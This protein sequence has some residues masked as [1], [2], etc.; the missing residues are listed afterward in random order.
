MPG[1][2]VHR[3]SLASWPL[4]FVVLGLCY[5]DVA[6]SYFR[7]G[8]LN[9][10]PTEEHQQ[11]NKAKIE[12]ELRAAFR[13]NYQ[14][15]KYYEQE[16]AQTT[17]FAAPLETEWKSIGRDGEAG[18]QANP[19][20]DDYAESQRDD[21]KNGVVGEQFFVKFVP[22]N[23]DL[24]RT[25]AEF[26]KACPTPAYCQENPKLCASST[27]EPKAYSSLCTA[28]DELYGLYLGDGTSE[29][30][31]FK[32]SQMDYSCSESSSDQACDTATGNF[33]LGDGRVSHYYES[34][35]D[36]PFLA[37]FTG[38]D[39]LSE[40]AQGS[41]GGCCLNSAGVCDETGLSNLLNNNAEGRFRL[42]MEIWVK[43]DGNRSPQVGQVPV[44]PVPRGASFADRQRFQVMAFD[45]DQDDLVFRFGTS[46]EMGGS[47]RD[48]T[49]SA[50]IGAS[51]NSFSTAVPG[52][53]EWS[54][55][56]DDRITPL[57]VGLYN[58]VV[59]VFDL[60]SKAEESSYKLEGR[61]VAYHPRHPSFSPASRTYKSKVPVDFL[62]YLY[63]GVAS[64]CNKACKAAEESGVPTFASRNGQYDKCTV[65]G[66]GT[67]GNSSLCQPVKA[68]G[69]CGELDSSGSLVPAAGACQVNQPPVWSPTHEA[70][71]GVLVNPGK[72]AGEAKVVVS[73]G[74]DF[75][76][77]VEAAD[78][79]SCTE[80][81]L[82]D[83][84]L[85][86]GAD[87]E[88][89]KIMP[90]GAIRRKFSWPAPAGHLAGIL[91]DSRE[92]YSRVC[93]YASDKYLQSQEGFY[94]VDLE[95]AVQKQKVSAPSA[96]RARSL[97]ATE[98]MQVL[99]RFDCKQLLTW[100]S[101]ERRFCFDDG[102]SYWCS[103]DQY[104]DYIWHHAMYTISAEGS[105]RLV[106]DGVVQSLVVYDTSSGAFV[107][108][109][110]GNV[111]TTTQS[112]K[113]GGTCSVRMGE[114]C[115]G[116]SSE[117]Y[118]FEGLV[119][120]VAIWDRELTEEEAAYTLFKMPQQLPGKELVAPRGDQMC[121]EKG[122]ILYARY[123]SPC[124]TDKEATDGDSC[125]SAPPKNQ[126]VCLNDGTM[127]SYN[128]PAGY[129]A[130]SEVYCNPQDKDCPPSLANSPYTYYKPYSLPSSGSFFTTSDVP[131]AYEGS[132]RVVYTSASTLFQQVA[133]APYLSKYDLHNPSQ[134]D[135]AT[136]AF[137]SGYSN[138]DGNI[139][140]FQD[141]PGAEK[142]ADP[143]STTNGYFEG[144]Y[145]TQPYGYYEAATCTLPPAAFPSDRYYFGVSND[146]GNTGSPMQEPITYMDYALSLEA[147]TERIQL[148]ES[149]YN[150]DL[151]EQFSLSFWVYAVPGSEG[152]V[153]SMG[154]RITLVGKDGNY[155]V[156]RTGGS[157]ECW[158]PAAS[159][160]YH[161]YMTVDAGSAQLYR[162]GVAFVAQTEAPFLPLTL[163]N[164]TGASLI[165]E[166]K[167]FDG[168][169]SM[170]D[171]LAQYMGT[172]EYIP[173]TSCVLYLRFTNL[174]DTSVLVNE[175]NSATQAVSPSLNLVSTA[176]PWE[177][178][179]V[180]SVNGQSVGSLGVPTIAVLYGEDTSLTVEGFNFARTEQLACLFDLDIGQG[181]TRYGCDGAYSVREQTGISPVRPDGKDTS[182]EPYP[183]M[184]MNNT[185]MIVSEII[186]ESTE[187]VFCFAPGS[188][189]TEGSGGYMGV[190]TPQ[191]VAGMP[192]SQ[193]LTGVPV[194]FL[195][196]S[197]ECTDGGYVT[198]D[199]VSGMV[200]SKGYFFS[201][202][203]YP[204]ETEEMAVALSFES[205][206]VKSTTMGN[207]AQ[208][209]FDGK[210]VY[211]YDD[212]VGDVFVNEGKQPANMWHYVSFSVTEDDKATL[213][214]DGVMTE[215]T[216]GSRPT[217]GGAFSLCMEYAD[218]EAVPSAFFSGL[219]AQ[220]KVMNREVTEEEHA[221]MIL[222][223]PTAFE[224][225]VS[226][227]D[228]KSTASLASPVY[229][230][231]YSGTGEKF[232]KAKAPWEPAT[233]ISSTP[234]TSVE[235]DGTIIVRGGNV[236]PSAF[237][238][239]F[240]GSGEEDEA[241]IQAGFKQVGAV[242]VEGGVGLGS[243]GICRDPAAN[244]LYV[245]NGYHNGTYAHGDPIQYMAQGNDMVDLYEGLLMHY[246][247]DVGPKGAGEPENTYY[248]ASGSGLDVEYPAHLAVADRD[249]NEE[250]AVKI[251]GGFA[252]LVIP[253]DK[254]DVEI[255]EVSVCIWLYM[256][257]EAPEGYSMEAYAPY[258]TDSVAGA[259][260][261]LTYTL[262]AE[263]LETLYVGYETATDM[264]MAFFIP[265]FQQFVSTGELFP[266]LE[267]C[268]DDVWVYA[269]VLSACEA[270]ARS[271]A[272]QHALDLTK[273]TEAVT[274]E[275]EVPNGYEM[276]IE[277]WVFPYS[278]QGR[279]TLF[280][281]DP[282]NVTDDGYAVGIADGR[283]TLSIYFD[284]PYE[285]CGSYMELSD[286]LILPNRWQH[287]AVSFNGTAA[288]FY[289]DGC[290]KDMAVF[291]GI[292]E[293]AA[294]PYAGA[295]VKLVY[296][297]AMG[298]TVMPI[299]LGHESMATKQYE[300]L[301]EAPSASRAFKGLV[302]DLRVTS[303]LRSPADIYAGVVCPARKR[304]PASE[305]YFAMNE[306][307]FTTSGD[308]AVKLPSTTLWVNAS[309]DDESDFSLMKVTGSMASVGYS[310]V[311][312]R[313]VLTMYTS[314]MK[315]RAA[316]GDQIEVTMVDAASGIEGAATVVDALD[317]NYFVEYSKDSLGGCGEFQTTITANQETIATMVTVLSPSWADRN[318]T[319]VEEIAAPTVGTMHTVYIQTY[320][321]YGCVG[322]STDEEFAVTVSGGIELGPDDVEVVALGSGRY[323]ATWVPP[324]EGEYHIH[325]EVASGPDPGPVSN[326][327]HCVT[328]SGYPGVYSFDG[329]DALVVE[330]AGESPGETDLDL[331][332]E[333]LTMQ[334]W[335]WFS[336]LPSGAAYLAVKGNSDQLDKS[337]KG[338]TFM[339]HGS[340]AMVKASIYVG[341]HVYREIAFGGDAIAAGVWVHLAA[342]YDSVSWT[343]YIN[344][345]EAG[346]VKYDEEMM[347]K[348]NLYYH[349]LTIGLGVSGA[350]DELVLWKTARTAEEVSA[351]LYCLHPA[352]EL[353]KVVAYFG[354]NDNTTDRTVVYGA[355]AVWDACAASLAASGGTGAPTCLTGMYSGSRASTLVT[356]EAAYSSPIS[357]GTISA[358]MSV[359]AVAESVT[360]GG[361][362]SAAIITVQDMCG[363]PLVNAGED[364]VQ[365][366]LDLDGVSYST[367]TAVMADPKRCPS[368]PSEDYPMGA[369]YDSAFSLTTAGV[370]TM[371]VVIAGSSLGPYSFTVEPGVPSS[372]AFRTPGEMV[373]GTAGTFG[374]DVLDEFQNLCQ[375]MRDWSVTFT[376]VG[377][378]YTIA[379]TIYASED[380]I[381]YDEG[382]FSMDLD[383]S[384]AGVYLVDLV[385]LPEV[386]ALSPLVSSLTV[387][388]GF[389]EEIDEPTNA[390][391]RYQHTSVV[392]NEDIYI[393]G[394]ALYNKTYS[395][396]LYV[397][398][399]KEE[400]SNTWEY[401]PTYGQQPT[402]R[403]SHTSVLYNNTMY[404]Y[405]GQRSLYAFDDVYAFDFESSTWTLVSTAEGETPAARFD[406]AAAVSDK[407]IMVIS[408]GRTAGSQLLEDMWALNLETNTWT[409][410]QESMSV[411]GVFGHAMAV[412]TGTT[413]AYLFGGY[414]GGGA[415]REF[416]RY[417]V[418]TGEETRLTDGCLSEQYAEDNFLPEALTA[419]FEHTMVADASFL[420]IFGGTGS[421]DSG[422]ATIFKYAWDQCA[423]DEVEL[424]SS[425]ESLGRYEHTAGCIGDGMYVQGG[426]ADGQYNGSTHFFPL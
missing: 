84:G 163:G 137:T 182:F 209:R 266:D 271:T 178:T 240:L 61:E 190:L 80:L 147:P 420:Y 306:G 17:N 418:V 316:G 382:S 336:E 76:F 285:P 211:Y 168:V 337:I 171:F 422:M 181:C 236:A 322:N 204:Y 202:W 393:F 183:V 389:W 173:N 384:T 308:G 129:Y 297:G 154:D 53:I 141:V 400:T 270:G 37:Y 344:G 21:N 203:V 172:K 237:T 117:Y 257:I 262:D 225:Y 388:G 90:D 387:T 134:S 198:A 368:N 288:L 120:E 43:G 426:K 235:Q 156:E 391:R 166:I 256:D 199:D 116:D 354:F 188:E 217:A 282:D 164:M 283:I 251:G 345:A 145:T 249:N 338:Y 245:S 184:Q 19:M 301:F 121:P 101:S 321:H 374:V 20:Y 103:K 187:K 317:G 398:S 25:A 169:I 63:P 351:G 125:E 128:D 65:C 280:S 404:V 29:E 290:Y 14:W 82:G 238:A 394:G 92:K 248:E 226:Y 201:V 106:V 210:S 310:N 186:F 371:T 6:G 96:S 159:M 66:Y 197:L 75:T 254:L 350:M 402:P 425:E 307:S 376:L 360:A 395:A 223:I 32:V 312:N 279:S 230:P 241:A 3:A 221:L 369:E 109:A 296:S 149:L 365:L 15:G 260:R 118:G 300:A 24:D 42:E 407:G 113:S 303:G 167:V 48:H 331:T 89:A 243:P 263:G 335:V 132:E 358:E 139:A 349:P 26:I 278:T 94:C 34:K 319:Q 126:A 83:V 35:T 73:P 366:T 264:T 78:A 362:Q 207:K 102:S 250:S 352:Q 259:W 72:S 232:V 175:V 334:T 323:A 396:D 342:V 49:P 138:R 74:E 412:P 31:V 16:W 69:A 253:F 268:V 341:E 45:A 327:D 385:A 340:S 5:Q 409:M 355:G 46:E 146:G 367:S 176:V 318:L 286:A 77:Y 191:A 52:M 71:N 234:P 269:R 403:Y 162:D 193:T 284:C 88:A 215:F 311:T 309:Y 347:P 231:A 122:R 275:A 292:Q 174:Y 130:G 108:W 315:Q 205:A 216:T 50:V 267:A 87:L 64:F 9:Y 373:A 95:I 419:R 233:V 295:P 325:V 57:T 353:S 304:G 339:Y 363:S 30:V 196:Q 294:S 51:Q 214:V 67:E 208:V 324:V 133:E 302:Y 227:Q 55:Y 265:L 11:E 356:D 329:T 343:G 28:W 261:L 379:D 213:N 421:S 381:V 299:L 153:I 7:Y 397:L 406:H 2:G 170:T 328:A 401:V 158:T 200:G 247:M 218:T 177:P 99:V 411:G 123:N 112:A 423:W 70:N 185:E 378:S 212:C 410:L 276:T 22:F 40:C 405:G 293:S 115:Q 246:T 155:C 408:G 105:G 372:F 161:I 104:E 298:S 165:D 114:A 107:D 220:V 277:S 332:F 148:E 326:P 13:R 375:E 416:Y 239:A 386:E 135:A 380:Q 151:G 228:F 91:A 18:I 10:K 370:Y 54:T 56:A 180:Y 110:D 33:L 44:L 131:V 47:T 98:G 281:T 415:T 346:S 424:G 320:D 305:Q 179:I 150:G 364:A 142:M 189:V 143:Y 273:S 157:D 272:V 36:S 222:G 219:V 79:D 124:G 41:E 119:D 68:D 100:H 399:D 348:E 81:V 97:A 152:T 313:Y 27:S 86:H 330:E 194:E 4:V 224:D 60:P 392:W 417:D 93:F 62:V 229:G 144:G 289:V 287:I 252:P 314:C 195:P 357:V 390:T 413:R 38:G 127:I 12:I 23:G 377:K 333:G 274:V 258:T 255:S 383:I 192:S 1:K 39:R 111:F 291:D 8:T 244:M 361:S 140:P 58:M 136:A 359:V 414:V 85:P 206:A 59:M 160:W 242:G